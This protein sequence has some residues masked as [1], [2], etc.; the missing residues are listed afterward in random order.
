MSACGPDSTG[1][2]AVLSRRRLRSMDTMET[3]VI[4]FDVGSWP[5]A[6]SGPFSAERQ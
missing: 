2:D 5:D 6:A 4:R 1:A 3:V